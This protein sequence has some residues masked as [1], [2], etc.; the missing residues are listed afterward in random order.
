[1]LVTKQAAWQ[2]NAGSMHL[3]DVLVLRLVN[4]RDYFICID[5][6]YEPSCFGQSLLNLMQIP[7]STEDLLI[8][9]VCL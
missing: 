4:G 1:M 6:D 5:G 7:M 8:D 3:R 2:L 9:L